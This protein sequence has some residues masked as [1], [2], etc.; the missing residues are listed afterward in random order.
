MTMMERKDNSFIS[1]SSAIKTGRYTHE[2]RTK[3]TVEVKL[4][5]GDNL[6]IKSSSEPT[7]TPQKM[8]PISPESLELLQMIYTAH[9]NVFI[10]WHQMLDDDM[11][12]ETNLQYSVR[13][14]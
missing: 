6:D 2:K 14:G 12:P 3:D 11:Y 5:K 1:I 9:K 13:F 10:L 7:K 4:L 8:A